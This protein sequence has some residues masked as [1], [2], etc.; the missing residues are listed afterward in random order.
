MKDTVGI[1]FL[2]TASCDKLSGTAL[3][4]L[5][6]PASDSAEE[7]AQSTGGDYSSD[8]RFVSVVI[9]FH[10]EGS[11]GAGFYVSEDTILTNYHVITWIFIFRDRFN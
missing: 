10:P 9:V 3:S 4:G 7:E 11:L 1:A 8:E 6:G 5:I 2:E